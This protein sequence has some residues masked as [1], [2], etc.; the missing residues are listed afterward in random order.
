MKEIIKKAYLVSVGDEVLSG[1]VVNTNQSYLSL[2]CE[3]LGIKV[4]YAA[5]IGDDHHAIAKVCSDFMASEATL[6]ITTGGLGPTH[7]DFT[8]EDICQYFGLEM[9]ERPEAKEVLERYFKGP[10]D[11]CNIKQTLFP[12]EAY[13]L[14][15]EIGT[16]DGCCIH[17]NH[18]KIMIMVGP[19]HE[20]NL[21]FEHYG[22]PYLKQFTEQQYYTQNFILMDGSESGFEPKIMTLN[23]KYHHSQINPYFSIGKIRY[24][25]KTETS[26]GEEFEA[27]KKEFKEIFK[28]YLL[29]DYDCE[30]EDVLVPYL[31][32]KGYHIS[33]AES[34]TG[35]LVASTLINVSGSSNVIN[36]A[37]V[38][39]ASSAKESLLSV[40]A[41][42][43]E[44]YNVVSEEVAAEMVQGLYEKTHAEVCLATTG[45]AG[46]TGGTPEI[47]VGTACIGIGIKGKI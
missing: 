4:I 32:E 35:G 5:A 15:N 23:H 36:E 22:I 24:Q 40:N 3:E 28:D 45:V 8:K 2:K 39:Y 9:V 12:Q 6:M 7:D 47:P 14:N 10:Y 16:A 34:L 46:P 30:V 1:K 31:K 42:T 18:K 26:Y 37:F 20:M 25:L 33:T 19:P 43:I 29:A 21:M 27:A 13:L 11:P 17:V 44:H 38:T 41:E